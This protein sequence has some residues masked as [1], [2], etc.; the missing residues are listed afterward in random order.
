MTDSFFI[1]QWYLLESEHID[2]PEIYRLMIEILL[3][4]VAGMNFAGDRICIM[5]EDLLEW[6]VT[7]HFQ[8]VCR[9]NQLANW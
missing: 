6:D 4:F 9:Y 8:T 5:Y 1:C 7:F 3:Q 2:Y